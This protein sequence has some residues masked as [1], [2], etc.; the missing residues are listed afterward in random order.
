MRPGESHG[1]G[2]KTGMERFGEPAQVHHHCLEVRADT[3][4]VAA[5]ATQDG[6]SKR[7]ADHKRGDQCA[8]EQD[9]QANGGLNSMAGCG[10]ERVDQEQSG[11]GCAGHGE[12]PDFDQGEKSQAGSNQQG[13][14]PGRVN[15]YDPR[16]QND[17]REGEAEQALREKDVGG[18]GQQVGVPKLILPEPGE[19]RLQTGWEGNI[20]R[21]EGGPARPKRAR[22]E[23]RQYGDRN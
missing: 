8:Q 23:R 3:D 17:R 14:A 7:S 13:A 9:H 10:P 1:G 21:A 22:C 6:V 20:V 16:L 2:V 12:H 15:S 18:P 5:T 19:Y 4:G 11:D